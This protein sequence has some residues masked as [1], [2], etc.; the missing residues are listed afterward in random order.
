MSKD[1]R[2]K[3]DAEEP[4]TG[5]VSVIGQYKA[6]SSW[7]AVLQF[8][9]A[10]GIEQ[11]V[12]IPRKECH[13]AH[14][15]RGHLLDRGARLTDDTEQLREMV[16]KIVL[17]D[18]P[19]VKPAAVSGWH[20]NAYLFGDRF[21][22][23]PD[24]QYVVLANENLR[25]PL[26]L[27][28][29]GSALA[30]S[31]AFADLPN[32][33][34]LLTLALCIAF[35]S[36]MAGPLGIEP[37]MIHFHGTSTGGK[38]VAVII[39]RSVFGNPGRDRF[40]LWNITGTGFEELA[41]EVRDHVLI[42]DELTFKTGSG[43]DDRLLKDIHYGFTANQPKRRSRLYAPPQEFAGEGSSKLGL[44]T[45]ELSFAE[46]ARRAGS[47]RFR[48]AVLR[49]LDVPADLEYGLGVFRT[50]PPNLR[51]RK[52]G[53]RLFAERLEAARSPT[54]D[55]RESVLLKTSSLGLHGKRTHVGEWL[56]SKM[57]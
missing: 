36:A 45:G 51:D 15:L 35:G 9:D 3:G 4:S 48:G 46:V 1:N 17:G 2:D 47:I 37:R 10:E 31:A 25:Y 8:R 29:R 52:N 34:Y 27:S 43:D 30:F 26:E 5:A 16:R 55:G 21:I 54:M 14:A 53:A 7:N 32:Q 22:G 40:P 42:L 28:P 33:S 6:G 13:S 57:S 49:A 38:T 39:A 20:G 18:L 50:L 56:T 24:P 12:P 44:S 41:A 19:V 23:V 11:T